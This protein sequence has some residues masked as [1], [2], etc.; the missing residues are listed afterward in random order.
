MVP[1]ARKGGFSLPSCLDAWCRAR[2]LVLVDDDGRALALGDVTATISL[3]RR[4][5]AGRPRAFCWLRTAN[6]SW[7]ARQ[8]WNSSATFSAVSGMESMPYCAFI[9]GFTKRQPMVVSKIC[10]SRLRRR[11]SPCP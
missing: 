4:P 5:T 9:S 7:S 10:A 6:A 8:I 1:P 2:M 11:C 3:A